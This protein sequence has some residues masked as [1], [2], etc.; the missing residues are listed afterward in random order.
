MYLWLLGLARLLKQ[1]FGEVQSRPQKKLV[2]EH[3]GSVDCQLE[4]QLMKQMSR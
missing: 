3:L 2:V 1:Y 4:N